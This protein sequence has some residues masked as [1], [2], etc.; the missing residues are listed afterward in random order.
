MFSD[1]QSVTLSGT[2]HSLARTS[3][4]DGTGAFKKA[5]AGL[6]LS[7][8]NRIGKRNAVTVR[9]DLDKIV[10]DPLLA[11]TSRPQSMSAYLVLNTPGN[12][13]FTAAEQEALAKA[14]VDYLGVAGN[15]TK[16][17]NGES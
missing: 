12:G 9:L 3:M 7:I 4:G 16:I 14:L 17:V 11:G 13:A 6:K 15:L 8:Q 2:A 10:A 1:P 5:S